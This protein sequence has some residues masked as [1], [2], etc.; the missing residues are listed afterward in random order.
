VRLLFGVQ[1][2][3][4][5]V[6]GGSEAACRQVAERL[7]ARG[8]HVEVV[9]SRAKSY[10]DWAD[11]YPE[12]AS[13]LNGV[14]VHRLGVR[15]P[16]VPHQFGP[17][18]GRILKTLRSPLFV[19]RDW[20]RLQGPDLPGLPAW[21]H[22][23]TRRFDVANFFTYLYP[24]TAFGLPQAARY[25]PTILFPTAHEEPMMELRV[26]DELIRAADGILCL[27]PEERDLVARRF[28][29]TPNAEVI[30][31]GVDLHADGDAR[32]FRDAN[33]IGDDPY[34]LFVGRIDPGKGSD[35][36]YRFFVEYKKRHPSSLRLVVVGEPVTELAPHD[37]VI[38][39]GF[40]DEHVKA[41]ALAG[42]TI[43]VQPSYFES[44]SLALCE[45]WVNGLPALVQSRCRVLE[46]QA[47]RS[48]GGIPYD[49]FAEFAESL[50]FLLGDPERRARL[51]AAGRAYV[52]ANY[53]W[54]VVL[55]NYE[56]FAAA[57]V[58]ARPDRRERAVSAAG[59][60]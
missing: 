54:D 55:D 33:G 51:G 29:F 25:R 20:L 2:Y 3:G 35:E 19:Q 30:G 13:E 1:R 11:H 42:A 59:H 40:V 12:G 10:V 28:R 26:F 46:G 45:G 56:R 16:R 49:G 4:E 22:E 43:L 47:R 60:G 34:L 24:T 7:A 27:T 39:T 52:E 8:H 36:L 48:G 23:H 57:V 53:D 21:L 50:Q 38:L 44:F 41:D 9:T 14:T 31:L 32:R 5:E 18:H 17:M 58:A 6:A 15:G 37:D